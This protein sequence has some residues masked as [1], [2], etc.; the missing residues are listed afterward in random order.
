[1]RYFATSNGKRMG[2]N[3]FGKK[4]WNL[5]NWYLHTQNDKR[6]IKLVEYVYLRLEFMDL[7]VCLSMTTLFSGIPK[8]STCDKSGVSPNNSSAGGEMITSGVWKLKKKI[9]KILKT[10]FSS[11]EKIMIFP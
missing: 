8:V 5:N 2:Y 10:L 3:E 7:I 9:E 1:M 11:F 6:L 4:N